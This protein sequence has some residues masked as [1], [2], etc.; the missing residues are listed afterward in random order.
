MVDYCHHGF[1]R[2]LCDI[3]R[4][5]ASHKLPLSL[6]DDMK[7]YDLLRPK[8]QIKDSLSKLISPD[9]SIRPIKPPE[10]VIHSSIDPSKHFLDKKR[11][12]VTQSDI[13]IGT[14]IINLKKKFLMKK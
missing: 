6:V 4:L 2:D 1:I 10:S 8:V 9:L 14:E 12:L 5:E 7:H 3:C 13:E 11:N